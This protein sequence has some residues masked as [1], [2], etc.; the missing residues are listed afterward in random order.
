[1][2]KFYKSP[3]ES[4]TNHRIKV[5][6]ITDFF[7][8]IPDFQFFFVFLQQIL[9]SKIMNGYRQRIADSLL[10]D[11]LDA[12]GAVLKEG[13]KASYITLRD[14]SIMEASRNYL[15]FTYF[16]TKIFYLMCEITKIITP[17]FAD[18][19]LDTIGRSQDVF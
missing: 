3:N 17:L 1:M 13:A 2:H 14:A 7:K 5:L 16:P 12:F 8:K 15:S 11:K 4:S 6:Q 9:N 10:K 19:K 18:G